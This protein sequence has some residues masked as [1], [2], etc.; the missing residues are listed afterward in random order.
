MVALMV[1]SALGSSFGR[2]VQHGTQDRDGRRPLS[3][4]RTEYGVG[5]RVLGHRAQWR[6][7]RVP[8]PFFFFFFFF[9]TALLQRGTPTKILL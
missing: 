2:Q 4:P 1:S 8:N 9:F 5:R 3:D 6:S 7:A